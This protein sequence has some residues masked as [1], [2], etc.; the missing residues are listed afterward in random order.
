MAAGKST[1]GRRLAECLG[2]SFVDL[3]EEVERLSKRTIPELFKEGGEAAF[4]RMEGAVTAALDET[5]DVVIATGGGWMARPELR[6]RW[7]D[8]V[9]VWLRV[10]PL[11]AW[12][13]VEGDLAARPMLDSTDPEGSL[14]SL[15]RE[16]TAAYE[17][18]ELSVNTDRP[19]PEEAAELVADLLAAAFGPAH[20]G[21]RGA[22]GERPRQGSSP[23]LSG[24]REPARGETETEE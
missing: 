18:S 2:Y 19:T 23:P 8:A 4:R 24:Y 12:E 9:R 21:S 6:D 7:P 17:L 5:R 14:R 20:A 3:D 16:R 1:V 10:G 22:T 11:A 13:R 15:M